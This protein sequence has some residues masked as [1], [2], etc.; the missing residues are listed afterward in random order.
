MI[1]NKNIYILAT[2]GVLLFSATFIYAET[3][4]LDNL[5]SGAKT[6]SL[7]V[8]Q[9][10]QQVREQAQNNVKQRKLDLQ[11]KIGQ[12][13]DQKKQDAAN[14]IQDQLNHVNQV[15]TDHFTLVLDRLDA[16]LQKIKSRAEKALANGRDTSKVTAAI[17]KAE[18]TIASARTAVAD[19]AKKTYTVD[20][21]SITSDASDASEQNNLISKLRTQFK[22]QKDQLFK[23]LTSLRDGLMKDAKNDVQSIFQALSQ[24]PN[25]DKEPEASPN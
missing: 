14:R 1:K 3:S 2:A 12:I 16:V 21:T 18:T 17:Q 9:Q 24:V 13:R 23:D 4:N 19:Q 22:A 8:K 20:A 15:W 25:V 10:I 6:R 7:Q 11:K 5:M